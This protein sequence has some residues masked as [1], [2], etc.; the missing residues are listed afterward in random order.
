MKR[1]EFLKQSALTTAGTMLIP[2]FL[3]ALESKKTTQNGKILVIIQWS[4]GNDGLNTVIPFR[5]DIYYRERP[6]LAVPSTEVLPLNDELGLNPA[7]LGLKKLYDQGFV[8]VL[9]NVGYPNPDRSHFRSMDI[10][11]TASRADEYLSTGWL[12][13]FLD[14]S[15]AGNCQ[16]AHLAVEVDDTLSLALKGEKIKGLALKDTEKLY[17]ATQSPGLKFLARQAPT[18][19]ED[20]TQ[21]YL[22]KTLAETVSSAAYVYEKAKTY[23][24]RHTYPN[25]ALG[26]QLKTIAEMIN[27]G[28]DT[29][30]YYTS[31]SGF[32]THVN[33]K[34]LQ[35][36]LLA[37][38]GEAIEVFVQD[39][40]DNDR[41]KDTVIMTFSEFGRRVAQNASNGTD[42]GT[43]NNVFLIHGG[44]AQAGIF[45]EMPNLSDLDEGDLKF[46][47]DFRRIYATLLQKQ[48]QFDPSKI[49]G[50][51]FAL[52]KWG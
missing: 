13:R 49:L 48:L 14:S 31:L 37:A 8:T 39:L 34:P 27:S 1:R 11:H 43:A 15:C 4:G 36:R 17:R 24:S 12:G 6:R 5:N 38:Y 50:G 44:Q 7:L 25:H 21:H 20:D 33:Q 26:R 22:Y 23:R 9:N 42:H 46:T 52:L 29:R 35:D 19:P 28:V 3:K 10:W 47:V 41:L 51:N 30:V 32:D 40:R 45:N 16:N 2:G 18:H